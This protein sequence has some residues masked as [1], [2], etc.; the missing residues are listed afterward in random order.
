[1][2]MVTKV[3]PETSGELLDAQQTKMNLG[4]VGENESSGF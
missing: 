1:M 4:S 2:E 3:D